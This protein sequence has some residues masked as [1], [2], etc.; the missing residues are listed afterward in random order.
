MPKKKATKN[1]VDL[2]DSAVQ[3]VLVELL[4]EFRGR[5]LGADDL[6][7]GYEGIPPEELKS[8]CCKDGNISEV[9]FDL[10]LKDLITGGLVKTGPMR[11]YDNKPGSGVFIFSMYSLNE[12]SHLT[13]DGYK[14]AT[15]LRTFAPPKPRIPIPNVHISGG[16]FHQS[17]IGAGSKISQTINISASGGEELFAKLREEIL[18]NIEDGN[19]RALVLE[20]LES[21]EAAHDQP[22]MLERYTQLVGAIGDHITVLQFFLPPILLWIMQHNQ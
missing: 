13:E 10:A 8:T 18:R 11:P 15:K 7:R 17:P 9:D 14:A 16:T 3:S 21:L 6:R 4:S 12:Y 2:A 20:R 1:T 5:G 22:T 19:K